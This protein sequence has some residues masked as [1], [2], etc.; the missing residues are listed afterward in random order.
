ML[1]IDLKNAYYRSPEH[2]VLDRVSLELVP[3]EFVVIIGTNGCGKSTLLKCLTGLHA[4]FEGKLELDGR[5]L[6][7]WPLLERAERIAYL[8]QSVTPAFSF[9]AEE[10]ILLSG[11]H[12]NDAVAAKKEAARL[13]QVAEVMNVGSLLPRAVDELSGGEWQRVAIAR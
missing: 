11:Y 8:P 9:T 3:G 6:A 10:V 1:S 5:M 13:K 12:R 4:A 7:N 2:S